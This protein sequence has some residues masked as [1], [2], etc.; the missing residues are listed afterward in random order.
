MLRKNNISTPTV[1]IIFKYTKMLLTFKTL[2]IFTIIQE[3][4]SLIQTTLRRGN[5]NVFKY[6]Q[7]LLS[8]WL[9]Y[10][11]S[12]HTNTLLR[13]LYPLHKIRLVIMIAKAVESL[14]GV[15][16][17]YF[18]QLSG[19]HIRKLVEIFVDYFNL[20][21]WGVDQRLHVDGFFYFSQKVTEKSLKLTK[22]VDSNQKKY[23][24]QLSGV[25]STQKVCAQKLVKIHNNRVRLYYLSAVVKQL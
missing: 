20:F 8:T 22:K 19:A 21:C 12:T 6:L 23:F 9:S 1:K 24:N 10:E 13:L 3:H 14:L 15:V 11:Y 18:D 16:V 25:H 7:V 5:K 4:V 2:L 17:V